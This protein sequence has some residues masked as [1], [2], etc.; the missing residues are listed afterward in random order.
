MHDGGQSW[1][2]P[3]ESLQR[4]SNNRMD[5]FTLYSEMESQYSEEKKSD[6]PRIV[7]HF[8]YYFASTAVPL[9]NMF[10]WFGSYIIWNIYMLLID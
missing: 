4:G 2:R 7:S 1:S 6:S 5:V 3:D 9:T 8:S 10:S